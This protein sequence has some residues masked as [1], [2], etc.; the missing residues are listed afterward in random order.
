METSSRATHSTDKEAVEPLFLRKDPTTIKTIEEFSQGFCSLVDFVKEGSPLN[1]AATRQACALLKSLTPQYASFITEDH[2]LK[3]LV[4]TSNGSCAGNAC[5][6]TQLIVF[7]SY[8]EFLPALFRL[9]RTPINQP[10]TEKIN[11]ELCP[12]LPYRVF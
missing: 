7:D 1:D 10:T 4:P 2:I 9:I 3:D 6:A 11:G 5:E 12:D 8:R